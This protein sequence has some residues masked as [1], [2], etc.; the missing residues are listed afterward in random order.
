MREI[1]IGKANG[2]MVPFALTAGLPAAVSST[3]HRLPPA[4]RNGIW[5]CYCSSRL[6]ACP[7]RAAIM[8]SSA[9]RGIEVPCK[10]PRYQ[11]IYYSKQWPG[12]I[13]W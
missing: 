6:F 9:W 4:F 5:S 10:A 3:K 13:F 7:F 12:C 2:L 1:V 11:I 8:P